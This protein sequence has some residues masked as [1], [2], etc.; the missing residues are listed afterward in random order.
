MATVKTMIEALAIIG[1][2]LI[3]TLLGMLVLYLMWG[4]IIDHLR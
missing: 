2:N 1:A 3:G 4:W